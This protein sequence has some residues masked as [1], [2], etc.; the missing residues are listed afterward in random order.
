MG[1]AGGTTPDPTYRDLGDHSEA[2]EVAYDPSVLSYERLLL[3]F[4]AQHTP[5]DEPW[6]RQYRSA[7]FVRT[8][9]E[10][11]AA[12]RAA[13]ATSVRLG[14]E[15]HTA[16]EAAGPFTPAEDDHQKYE[17]R[18]LEPVWN[19]FVAMYPTSEA[20]VRSTAV[21][22]ANAWAAGALTEFPE[23]LGLSREATE[24]LRHARD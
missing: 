23:G 15:V 13:R 11:A 5:T 22:R 24:V 16:I 21:A 18:H 20:Q 1:Y 10:R 7:V 6:L 8:P 3:E 9:E 17:L 2:I 19:E 14:A 4:F 12:E